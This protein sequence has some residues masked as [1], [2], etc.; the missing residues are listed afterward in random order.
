MSKVL[1]ESN[2]CKGCTLWVEVC[3]KK[4]L[5]ISKDFNN[6]GYHPAVF[7]N[8]KAF[9]DAEKCYGCGVC[10]AICPTEAIKLHRLERSEMYDDIPQLMK[11]IYQE[12][13]S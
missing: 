3:P 4:C 10:A 6:K 7:K 9:V 1:I 8:E 13:R 5:E 11:K 12:N 2:K